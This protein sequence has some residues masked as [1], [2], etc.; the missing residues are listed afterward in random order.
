M[1]PLALR[2]PLVLTMLAS[3]LILVLSTWPGALAHALLLGVLLSPLWLPIVLGTVLVVWIRKHRQGRLVPIHRGT[4]VAMLIVVCISSAFVRFQ[5]PRRVA[6][7]LS[8]GSFEGVLAG[9]PTPEQGRL[10]LRSRLGLYRVDEVAT[11]LGGGVYFRIHSH[12]DG[13]DRMSHGFAFRPDREGTPFGA[14]QYRLH[15]LCDDW[16]SFQASDDW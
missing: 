10:P 9:A 12:P 3:L 13:P 2:G 14:A 4:A 16:Y 1:M 5:V 11:D 15:H 7:L 6:F 8:R